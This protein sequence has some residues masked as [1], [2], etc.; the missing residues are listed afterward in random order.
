[1][2]AGRRFSLVVLIAAG[3][4]FLSA[5]LPRTAAA[6]AGE[7]GKGARNFVA[8]MGERAL[9][10]LGNENLGKQEKQAEFRK[11]LQDSFD[12]A[13]IGRFV[14]GRNWRTA[15][16]EQRTEYQKL[17]EAMIVK[18]YSKRF[19]DY[20]GQKFEVRNFRP[21]GENDT[22]VSSYIVPDSGQEIGVDWRVRYKNGRYKIVDVIVE[23]VSMAL[24]QRS[25]FASVIQ[26]GGGNVQVLIDHLKAP[27]P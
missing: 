1:M 15:T 26:R 4:V 7:A 23:G 6:E 19:D 24:T 3:A 25:D 20:Q 18:V 2:G 10:F 22:I 14:L 12:M 16:P 17:F 8:T 13:T 9:G 21:D 11:L 5:A 27:N